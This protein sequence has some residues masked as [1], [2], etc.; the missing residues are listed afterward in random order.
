[1][2]TAV[3]AT[4][5]PAASEGE[6]RSAEVEKKMERA[7]RT[8][9]DGLGNGHGRSSCQKSRKSQLRFT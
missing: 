2:A 8:D 4:G 9:C 1:V 3:V 7:G 6:E 5:F